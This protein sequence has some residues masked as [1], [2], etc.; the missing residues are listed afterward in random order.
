MVPPC[1]ARS[2]KTESCIFGICGHRTAPCH[3]KSATNRGSCT[4]SLHLSP[5]ISSS[6]VHHPPLSHTQSHFPPLQFPLSGDTMERGGLH[7]WPAL[8]GILPNKQV[9]QLFI[10]GGFLD[11]PS[12]KAS[13]DPSRRPA[14]IACKRRLNPFHSSPPPRHVH[15]DDLTPCAS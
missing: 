11:D 2:V 9:Q 7:Y 14:P 5:I 8:A 13:F 10:Q 15:I 4:S 1:R 3:A 12:G 6:L